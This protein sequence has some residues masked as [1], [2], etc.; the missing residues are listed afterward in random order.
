MKTGILKGGLGT[1]VIEAVNNSNIKDFKI[2]TFGYNDCFVKHGSTLEIEEMH[3][4]NAKK[5]VKAL[6][7]T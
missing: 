4:L 1:A 3:E 5:I 7:C 6:K 2:K